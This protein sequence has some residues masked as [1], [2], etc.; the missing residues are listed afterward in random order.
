[1]RSIA[2]QARLTK[3]V[4]SSHRRPGASSCTNVSGKVAPPWY[5]GGSRV[6]GSSVQARCALQS[7][8]PYQKVTVSGSLDVDRAVAGHA[9]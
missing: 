3:T 6:L 8:L 1:M 7:F 2:G 9:D 4:S 5:S